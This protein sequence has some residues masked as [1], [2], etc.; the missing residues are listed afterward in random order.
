MFDFSGGAVTNKL[1]IPVRDPFGFEN[2]MGVLHALTIRSVRDNPTTETCQLIRRK[3]ASECRE[4]IKI[5]QQFLLSE[6]RANPLPIWLA[7]RP[8]RT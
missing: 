2:H 3:C 4:P 6:Q 1:P 5:F 7:E 8:A